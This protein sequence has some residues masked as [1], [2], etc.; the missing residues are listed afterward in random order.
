MLRIRTYTLRIRML[1][2]EYAFYPGF[3]VYM[4]FLYALLVCTCPFVIT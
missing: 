4:Q 1:M 3:Q 2:K